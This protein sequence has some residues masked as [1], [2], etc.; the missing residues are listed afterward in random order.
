MGG[1]VVMFPDFWSI[2]HNQA[3]LGFYHHLSAG[4]H[5]E[6]RFMLPEFGLNCLGIA[7][8]TGS[9]TFGLSWSHFG[10]S[11]YHEN[12]LGLALG[13][14]FH[15][16]FSAGLQIDY[17]NRFIADESGNTGTVAVE[18]GILAE[19]YEGLLLGL[20]VFNP[21][22]SRHPG[23]EDLPVILR[24]GIGYRFDDRISLGAE[25]CKDL[26]FPKAMFSLGAEYRLIDYIYIRTGIN[27]QEYVHHSF[28]LG[29]RLHNF[30]ANIAFSFQQIAG[31][32]PYL[33]LK[34]DFR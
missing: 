14:A 24:M 7:I 17:L 2:W 4:F 22:A 34:Y 27:V 8:P 32:T 11:R 19:L 23:G 3:G 29:F 10:Y 21:T 6:N 5:H 18:A 16:R 15:E 9:G 1:T 25:T 31:Y 12:K 20:H 30:Q 26:C 13:R 28:G 33:S